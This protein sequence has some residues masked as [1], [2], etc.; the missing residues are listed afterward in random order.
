MCLAHICRG[1]DGIPLGQPREINP[2]LA[3]FLL[4]IFLKVTSYRHGLPVSRARDGA[5]A[6]VPVTWIPAF[7]RIESGAGSA[8]MTA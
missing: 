4:I 3:I 6:H 2:I 5:Q 8:G 1:I 7:P